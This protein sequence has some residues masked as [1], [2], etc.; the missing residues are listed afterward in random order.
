MTGA[1]A[2]AEALTQF[3]DQTHWLV[4]ISRALRDLR[5]QQ[6]SDPSP[7]ARTCLP[8]RAGSLAKDQECQRF[9]RRNL[10]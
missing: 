4:E 9:L 6:G 3:S 7:K 10:H 2:E 1:F 8:A 5:E